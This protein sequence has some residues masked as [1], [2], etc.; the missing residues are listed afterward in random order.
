MGMAGVVWAAGPP[1]AAIPSGGKTGTHRNTGGETVLQMGVASLKAGMCTH[2]RDA[3]HPSR[4]AT[5]PSEGT[6]RQH[7]WDTEDPKHR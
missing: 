5:Q 3:G 6:K 2:T 4:M 7:T 1:P